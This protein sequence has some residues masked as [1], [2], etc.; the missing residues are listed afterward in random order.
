MRECVPEI[1]GLV[2]A[3][4]RSND[5]SDF[6]EICSSTR[7]LLTCFK[8]K[9]GD[10]CRL[11][12]RNLLDSLLSAVIHEYEDGD[13]LL[14]R[15]MPDSCQPKNAP[16]NFGSLSTNTPLSVGQVV[17]RPITDNKHKD[18]KTTSNEFKR[19]ID[20][21]SKNAVGK[22]TGS[23][24]AVLVIDGKI[25][26]L[27]Y[28]MFDWQGNPVPPPDL[29]TLSKILTTQ[30]LPLNFSPER[31]GETVV[32]LSKEEEEEDN[33]TRNR[34]IRDLLEEQEKEENIVQRRS[35]KKD[36]EKNGR[37]HHSKD[38]ND[39]IRNNSN[40]VNETVC[41]S[42]RIDVEDFKISAVVSCSQCFGS[43]EEIVHKV[44]LV[45]AIT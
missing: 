12:Q 35:L 11:G 2:M 24:E 9:I 3:L 41:I 19:L 26:I 18:T 28:Q 15:I 45:T 8:N 44:E 7:C 5:S 14:D 31:P 10:K 20:H 29:Q 13:S 4:S 39:A 25:R 40:V 16:K 1:D 37:K 23:L 42:F 34:Q 21:Q 38:K 30:A 6:V 43:K 32:F 36:D 33:E 22:S 27:R 17:R